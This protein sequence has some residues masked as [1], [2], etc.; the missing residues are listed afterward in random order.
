M[1]PSR[2]YLGL[3]YSSTAPP[4]FSS[5]KPVFFHMVACQLNRPMTHQLTHFLSHCHLLAYLNDLLNVGSMLPLSVMQRASSLFFRDQSPDASISSPCPPVGMVLYENVHVI[6]YGVA[7]PL[8]PVI[9][10]FPPFF[11][12]FLFD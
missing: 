7:C 10:G 1:F 2:P 4:F 8:G 6:F 3:S 9:V 12:P 5:Q 11:P